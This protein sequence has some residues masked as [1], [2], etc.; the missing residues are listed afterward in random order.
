MAT[1]AETNALLAQYDALILGALPKLSSLVDQMA[2]ISPTDPGAA[3][4]LQ[5]L[6]SQYQA[7]KAQTESQMQVVYAKY[8]AAYDSLTPAQKT[9]AANSPGAKK[10]EQVVKD[11][12]ANKARHESVYSSKKAAVDA[13]AKTASAADPAVAKVAANTAN[14]GPKLTGAASDDSGAKQPNPAGSTGGPPSSTATKTGAATNSSV[15]QQAT[16]SSSNTKSG[17]AAGGVTQLANATPGRRLK[18]PLGYLSSYTYQL[19]LY[20]ITPDAYEAF[21]ATGR[22]N[23][24]IF[25]EAINN[26]VDPNTGQK[27]SGGAFLIAQSAGAGPKSARA[28]GFEFDYGIDNLTFKHYT[29]PPA[30]G[31]SAFNTEITFT[32]T[33]PYGFSFITKL[34][35]AQDAM[36]NYAG[37]KSNV[38]ENPSKQFF[39]L[40]IRFF[41]YDAS[42]RLMTGK[43]IYDGQPLDPN[44]SGNGA[45]FETY[46]DIFINS[47]KFKID[48]KAILYNITAA[49][50]SPTVGFGLKRGYLP[51]SMEVAG[52]TV[53]DTLE[54]LAAKLNEQQE[55]ML[56]QNTMKYKVK[57]SFEFQGEAETIALSK[58]AKPADTN[59]SNTATTDAKS[60]KDS[61]PKKE[62]KATPKPNIKT[63]SLAAGPLLSQIDAI[64]T[65]SD[66]LDNAMKYVYTSTTDSKNNKVEEK[67][68]ASI[69]WYNCSTRLSNPR[70]DP[71]IKDWAYD[72]T[73]VIQ[74]Y[75]TPVI[76]TVFA[77]E[78]V[79]FYGPHKRYD[80]WYTGKNTEILDYVQELNNAYFTVVLAGQPGAEPGN[81]GTQATSPSGGTA[82]T[83]NNDAQ[84]P[85]DTAKVPG[86]PSDQSTPGQLGSGGQAQA[87][88]LT[89]LFDAA[90]YAHAT[91]TI[92]GDPDFLVQ[93]SA[94]INEFYNKFYGTNNFTI[95]PNGGQVFFEI[96][97]KEAVDYESQTGL[98]SINE[99]IQFWK[100]PE[101]IS[102]A[103]KPDG[104]P[105]VQGLSYQ[106]VSVKSTFQ[107][108]AFKQTLDA[109]INTFG[110]K[111]ALEDGD[112]ENPAAA[113]STN[114][115]PATN[116]A[117][118]ENSSS[119]TTKDPPVQP[120]ATTT[121]AAPATPPAKKPDPTT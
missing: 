61:N 100:Y 58:M 66:Y 25:N 68:P 65:K 83:G 63:T 47:I 93:D 81:G 9:E 92:M 11:A 101:N 20:M 53:K 116:N 74:P 44:A 55:S 80:Y 52:E 77:A 12:A 78:G 72:I 51:A 49:A 59:K 84:G 35:N 95:N 88:Y 102:K 43:E 73:Y 115:G 70:W 15:T 99:S 3:A 108:G 28:P 41:G 104:S 30:N 26:E 82:A 34:R 33:E 17:A 121:T 120:A 112:R 22:K 75:E 105:L 79:P 89:N 107:N 10:H 67:T 29:S 103:K 56:K 117:A 5:S 27:T 6:E 87:T 45:L 98:L 13:A 31:S 14:A 19:S 40:G 2:A 21:V 38:P 60:T 114:A 110:G 91:I 54:N 76:N 113:A 69:A 8:S 64:I 119:G 106:L 4:K 62:V 36:I 96:D 7:L 23:I 46:Y 71:I 118:A 57:Y 16:A 42:G 97:F 18:N 37:G 24:N 90:S 32:I 85:S 50:V 86:M 109:F 1:V 39:I 111:G 94:S 48:G